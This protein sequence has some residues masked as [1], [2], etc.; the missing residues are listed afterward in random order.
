MDLHA[1][2]ARKLGESQQ[3]LDC[4]SVWEESPFYDDRER[5]ALSWA[6]S[7]T[8]LKENH[9]SDNKYEALKGLFSEEEIVDL[10]LIISLMNTWNRIA[11]SFRRA[12]KAH[13]I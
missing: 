8:N 12:Q 6:E 7:V 1:N 10:T 4:L 3:R 2:E 9:A 13:R 5:A 11:I